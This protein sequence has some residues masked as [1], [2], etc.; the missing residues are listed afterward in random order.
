MMD[1]GTQRELIKVLLQLNEVLRHVD[2]CE[3]EQRQTVVEILEA[4]NERCQVDFV[5]IKAAAYSEPLSGLAKI[6]VQTD[7]KSQTTI[8]NDECRKLCQDIIYIVI[9]KL[10][11]ETEIKKDIVFLPYKASMWDSLESV[12]KA[13]SDDREHCNTYVIP[14]AYAD[15]NPD[16]TASEWYCEKDEYPKYVPVLNWHDYPWEKLKK[17]HPDVIF[18]H[19]PYDNYN[20]VTSI[21]SQYYSDRLKKCTNKLVYIPY[22]V[23]GD[24]V[25]PHF[26]Q[27]KGVINADHVIVQ[28]D[29]IKIQYE[30]NYT[31]KN[32]Y[33]DKFLALGSPKF[34]KLFNSRKEDFTLPKSWQ[35]I[36]EGKKVVLYNTSV[37]VALENTKSLC[38]K[39]RY[40]LEKFKN[41]NDVAFWWRPHPLMLSTLK[42][43]R[44]DVASEYE[45][46]VKEYI[47]GGWGIYDDTPEM[48]RAIIY[49]D[50]YYGDSSSVAVLYKELNPLVLIQDYS[51]REKESSMVGKL[52]AGLL[53][54]NK[55]YFV[56]Y[57]T[58][59]LYCYDFSD[60]KTTLLYEFKDEKKG[61]LFGAVIKNRQ[62]VYF[63]PFMGEYIYEWVNK[64][65]MKKYSLPF[66][67]SDNKF[68]SAHLYSDKIYCIPGGY[69]GIVEFDCITKE[70]EINDGWLN[71]YNKLSGRK[72]SDFFRKS[73]L[74]NH[75]IYAPG[76]RGDFV[77]VYDL[78][79]KKI[80]MKKVS[81]AGKGFSSIAKYKDKW[82][83]TSR[84][85]NRIYEVCEENG[86]ITEYKGDV[87]IT[88]YKD[89][90]NLNDKQIICTVE[91]GQEYSTSGNVYSNAG[92]LWKMLTG[93]IIDTDG[94]SVYVDDKSQI[95]TMEGV[96][97]G[98][99]L[100]DIE[101]EKK[102]IEN[103]IH[104]NKF[105]VEYSNKTIDLY[106]KYNS[107][108]KKI[109]SSNGR[110]IYA[111][112]MN[113]LN[114]S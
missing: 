12:W 19:N 39:L 88:A 24:T 91:A 51:I 109:K 9:N 61:R 101:A 8:E 26:V 54:D 83:V 66:S 86:E 79:S 50:V 47:R 82:M 87:A 11:Q 93:E 62:S 35:N 106:I 48:E 64:E 55:L 56:D 3:E 104:N 46:T 70:L 37:T 60:G 34:D 7:W 32:T 18:I 71:E 112:I 29:N 107:M 105:G 13:A 96:V 21:D 38:K 102:S 75:K 36:I 89:I 42:A 31:G 65:E 67:E 40:V 92:C 53:D 108:N 98:R 52:E 30:K 43:M 44:P 81:G 45:K 72:D 59:G 90:Y 10:R 58:N 17:M 110:K 15:R 49:S 20:A 69:P 57:R 76:C 74:I 1:R 41:R 68:F 103:Y 33:D 99:I 113:R 73:K 25:A 23:V 94:V 14:I 80:Q 16:G 4:V 2:F 100:M 6:I 27:T 78:K 5:T 85:D 95:L 77:L 84:S 97:K 28:N 111:Y 22:F 63:L 114:R